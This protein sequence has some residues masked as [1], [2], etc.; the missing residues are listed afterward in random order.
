MDSRSRGTETEDKVSGVLCLGDSQCSQW[1]VVGQERGGLA[2][3]RR[4][5]CSFAVSQHE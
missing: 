1:R 3:E 2:G 5:V 4:S